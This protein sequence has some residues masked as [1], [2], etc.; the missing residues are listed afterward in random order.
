MDISCFGLRQSSVTNPSDTIYSAERRS[1]GSSDSDP[2]CDDI[3]HPWFNTGNLLA[4]S[5]DMEPTGGAVA[6]TRHLGLANYDF[7]DGHAKAMTWG[8]TY[9]PPNHNLHLTQQ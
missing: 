5:N 4:P 6:T 7:S 8:A 2:F 1:T 3:Y 9:A